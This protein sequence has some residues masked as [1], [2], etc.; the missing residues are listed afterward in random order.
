MVKI[1]PRPSGR[2]EKP[3]FAAFAV[4]PKI[5]TLNWQKI[6]G[7]FPDLTEAWGA[8]AGDFKKAGLSS[9]F[10]EGFF[11]F[12]KKINPEKEY[13][14]LQKHGV[15]IL[16]ILDE[17]YPKNL[18]EIFTP[19]VVLYVK[20]E[21][22][23]EDEFAIGVVGARK[24]TDYGK[25]ATREI[26]EGMAEAGITI[27]SGLAL[28][29]DAEAHKAA[30]SKKARTIAVLANGLDQIYPPTNKPIADKILENGAIISE[31]PIG[32][33]PLKQNFPA[34]NRIIS[35]LSLGVLI[36]EAGEHSGTLHTASFALEQNRQIYAVPGPIY[37][38][39]SQG[40]NNLIKSGAK[41]VSC[42]ED[43]LEDLGIETA[44]AEKALPE[45]PD[46]VMI[47]E[48]LE[49]ES[50]HID[51]I[52]KLAEKPAQEISRILTMMEI[53][54]KVKH[55]GGMVYTLRK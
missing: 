12:R 29:L 40:P 6:L 39:L 1:D 31:Q 20:G 15:D 51:E 37:N 10:V 55:L 49:T 28:G 2:R 38:P 32:M 16:T 44:P 8:G 47:F 26:T 27:V 46:E 52:T 23:P 45:T 22:K 24:A 18:K 17:S 25:R 34:R 53:K 13:E 36:T 54:E 7:Y 41:A 50:R 42:A 11:D 5:N 30:I 43:I 33:P 9:D 35:G 4:F 14:K 48:I 3:Y 21:L 19:P